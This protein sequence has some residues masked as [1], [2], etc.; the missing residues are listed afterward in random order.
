MSSKPGVSMRVTCTPSSSSSL[1]IPTSVVHDRKPL[2]VLRDDL[3]ARLM[4]YESVNYF[5]K[6]NLKKSTVVFPVPVEPI[7]L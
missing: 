2:E 6:K 3:L 1:D 4:N 7:T 5:T